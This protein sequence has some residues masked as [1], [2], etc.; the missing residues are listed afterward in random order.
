V[1]IVGLEDRGPRAGEKL[2]PFEAPDQFGRIQTF[3]TIRG[4]AG[5]LIVFLRSADW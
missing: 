5:G 2:P 3:E 4:P 1:S